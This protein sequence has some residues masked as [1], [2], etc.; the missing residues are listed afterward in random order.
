MTP[1]ISVVVPTYRRP[2][3]LK[4][5][6]TALCAQDLSP[7]A[8]EIVVADDG[9]SADTQA[10]VES[11]C[12]EYAAVPA[13]RYLEVSG[14]HGPAAA[15]NCGWRNARGNFI[16]FT[17]DDCQPAR[18][19]LWQ[20]LLALKQGADAV[21]GKLV[22]PVPSRPTDYEKDASHLANAEFITANCFCRKSILEQVGGF[23][24]AFRLAWREDS[25]LFFNLLKADARIVH[26]PAAVVVHP[27][28]PAAWGISL[29]Q[30]RKVLFDALLYKKH[31]QYYRARIRSL[32]PWNYYVIVLSLALAL[33]LV[34][35]G[36][37]NGAAL[38]AIVW[39]CFSL[40]FMLRRLRGTSHTP[41]HITEM[42]VTSMLIP[43][44][45]LYWH[46]FG[47][48]KFRVLYV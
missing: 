18:E 5:C 33:G 4:K 29:S 12:E 3:L 45:A 9:P 41:A 11:F 36:H 38:A 30:Q 44:L 42:L 26:A 47:A 16:A 24:E 1:L 34:L 35:S 8:F 22:M 10:L 7:E 46:W 21:W 43:P 6:L 14:R 39:L 25:D 27:I 19:W 28:R 15:R 32:P 23:D 31:P 17:D 13:I 20:G 2:Q 37:F 48:V 40:D